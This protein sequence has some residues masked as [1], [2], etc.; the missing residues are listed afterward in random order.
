MADRFWGASKFQT[1]KMTR[2][3]SRLGQKRP[4]SE[5]PERPHHPDMDASTLPPLRRALSSER[6]ALE[7]FRPLWE[8]RKFAIAHLG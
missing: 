4:V 6:A 3:A 5:S 8:S 1:G 7:N 2:Q